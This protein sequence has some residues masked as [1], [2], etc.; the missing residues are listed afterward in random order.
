MAISL[1]PSGDTESE[2]QPPACWSE[3]EEVLILLVL[4]V[5]EL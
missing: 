4:L 1:I 3:E 5:L 2:D